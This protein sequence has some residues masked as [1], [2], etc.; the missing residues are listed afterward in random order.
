MAMYL[1]THP[2]PD[3]E[4]IALCDAELIGRVLANRKMRLDLSAYAPFY[5]GKKV[6]AKEA[7]A[8]L[9][10]AK[11]ANIVGKR[12]LAAAKKAGLPVSHAMTIDGIPHLQVYRMPP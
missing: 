2:S 8:A 9:E 12:A 10:G 1:K 7:A 6:D 3:G 4:I 5:L 11:N